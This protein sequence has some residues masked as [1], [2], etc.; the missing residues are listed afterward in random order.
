VHI[1]CPVVVHGDGVLQ[2]LYTR[3]QAE[4]DFGVT[5]C[6]SK[7]GIERERRGWGEREEG[8]ERGDEWGE[9]TRS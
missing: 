4:R 5:R 8:M 1:L 7:E 6:V 3:L 2:R 9:R